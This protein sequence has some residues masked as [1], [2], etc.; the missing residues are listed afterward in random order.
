MH[1]P[2]RKPKRTE[3]SRAE[4]EF[5]DNRVPDTFQAGG[6]ELESEI[7]RGKSDLRGGK[8][9][10]KDRT[11]VIGNPNAGVFAKVDNLAFGGVEF[12]PHGLVGGSEKT[13]NFRV[14]EK[15]MFSA[16]RRVVGETSK[17]EGPRAEERR[18]GPKDGVK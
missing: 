1:V 13:K 16:N 15:N 6:S 5:G 9:G 18:E 11:E 4:E 2:D 7:P 3:M 17:T 12:Q 14:N 8:S 10:P